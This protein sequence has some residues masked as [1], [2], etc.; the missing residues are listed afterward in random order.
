MAFMR[1]GRFSV[2]R[3]TCGRGL[4]TRTYGIRVPCAGRACLTSMRPFRIVVAKLRNFANAISQSP[5][6]CR[7]AGRTPAIQERSVPGARASD[8][9]PHHRVPAGRR[10]LRR[11]APRAD[12]RGACERVAAPRGA[13]GEA[14]GRRPQRRQPGLLRAARPA[15]DRGPGYD[16]PLLPGAS[17]G[18]A[19]DAETALMELNV[20]DA[21]RLLGASERDVHRW[22]DEGVIPFYE[23]NDQPRFN[24][25]ELLGWATS[26]RRPISVDVF[27][28]RT[29]GAHDDPRLV[30]AL[31]AGGV[32]ADVPGADRESVLRAVVGVL[33]L[34]D[35]FDR[36]H[37][38]EVLLARE[39]MGSTGIGDGIAIPHVRNPVI[40]NGA[41]AS[42]AV[43]YLAH[44]VA[45]D[46][47][48]GLPVDTV[49]S[50]VSPTIRGHL[51]LLAKLSWALHDPAFKAAVLR[52]AAEPEVL[53][54]ARR[55]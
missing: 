55:I 9:Y 11:R 28:R 43:C 22:I 29:D 25:A 10:G 2:T 15:A 42:I 7:K 52:R 35:G 26:R 6:R 40:L 24:R 19:R 12:R 1:S 53:A 39:A 17:A 23:I 27:E 33:R 4:S 49:F 50:L 44:P 20:R 21:A 30:E 48:D 45:F 16:A 5:P 14:A 51:R 18:S 37:L 47:I 34:P 36:D 54:E 32:H 13:P 38:V 8:P 46:A 41:A 31:K 3:L